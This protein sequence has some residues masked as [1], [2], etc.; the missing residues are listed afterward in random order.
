M[1]K[2]T[3]EDGLSREEAELR[4]Y[5]PTGKLGGRWD[6]QKEYP[7]LPMAGGTS[8]ARFAQAV[9]V[10]ARRPSLSMRTPADAIDWP[11][12]DTMDHAS[13]RA[14]FIRAYD[15]YHRMH[16]TTPAQLEAEHNELMQAIWQSMHMPGN[17]RDNVFRRG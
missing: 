17:W 16:P 10:A 5:G 9:P 6:L 12:I 7:G 11:S 3:E 4:V 1:V 15:T 13:V 8:T 14:A 2:L